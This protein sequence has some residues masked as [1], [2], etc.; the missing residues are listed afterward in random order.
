MGAPP[1][2]VVGGSEAFGKEAQIS[3]WLDKFMDGG[4]EQKR[5]ALESIEASIPGI[6]DNEAVDERVVNALIN[7]LGGE[8]QPQADDTR[9][10]S[11]TQAESDAA[12][13]GIKLQNARMGSLINYKGGETLVFK[14]AH[15]LTK[16]EE[17]HT[18][19]VINALCE[20]ATD[21]KNDWRTRYWAAVI[22]GARGAR[23]QWDYA[24]TT[25]TL[26]KALKDKNPDVRCAAILGMGNWT[27]R[28]NDLS[29]RDKEIDNALCKTLKKDKSTNV[30]AC[31]ALVLGNNRGDD[32]EVLEKT[33]RRTRSK[34]LKKVASDA[35]E[36]N[37]KTQANALRKKLN[38]EDREYNVYKL[39]QLTDERQ[40]A[41]AIP[42]L[43]EIL[44][45]YLP[46]PSRE[47]VESAAGWRAME[48]E[49]Q[50]RYLREDMRGSCFPIPV[51]KATASSHMWKAREDL[52]KSWNQQIAFKARDALISL[53]K[54]WKEQV[55][56][57]VKELL[58]N[59]NPVFRISALEILNAVDDRD[60]T[61][62]LLVKGMGDDESEVQERAKELLF[63]KI[64][65]SNEEDAELLVNALKS[66][67][68]RIQ[69]GAAWIVFRHS[70]PKD[71]LVPLCELLK[72]EKEEV[73]AEAVQ[74]LGAITIRALYQAEW[75]RK[76][77]EKDGLSHEEREEWTKLLEESSEFP[78]KD[79]RRIISTMQAG[80]HYRSL[81][82]ERA[83]DASVSIDAELK[84]LEPTTKEQ[85]TKMIDELG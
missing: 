60:A 55:T 14:A 12:Y 66:D 33:A 36:R 85:L 53:G 82:N 13:Y 75:A 64:R 26:R 22:L 21:K 83:R 4:L 74:A 54:E 10:F 72:H 79:V 23:Q 81:A 84:K 20:A 45:E 7:V 6:F 31:A 17:Q 49:R 2:E 51:P 43:I 34:L 77:L 62:D 47:D 44:G 5:E 9:S 71:A 28:D 57:P 42:L 63:E 32:V 15:A 52:V 65:T 70:W 1:K 38:G 18:G 8:D 59:E 37:E 50:R 29:F 69:A 30:R 27:A 39:G 56:A 76:N 73:R 25:E 11:S 19:H 24:Q 80:E 78:A 3:I 68:S 35:A 58:E 67:N 16:M 46:P 41:R 48:D 61:M 40:V